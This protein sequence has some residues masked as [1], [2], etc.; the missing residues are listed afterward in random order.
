LAAAVIGDEIIVL[1]GRNAVSAVLTATEIYSPTT[2][3]WR[4]GAP[5]P[6]GRSGVAAA[7]LDARVYLFGGERFQPRATFDSAERYDP[8]TDRWEV[9]P[10]MPNARH[11]LGAAALHGRIHVIAGGPQAGL[12]FSDFHEVLEPAD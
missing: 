4:E 10:P 6:T 3:R 9:L 8:A 2:D 12:S 5:V 11:G 7:A 1:A